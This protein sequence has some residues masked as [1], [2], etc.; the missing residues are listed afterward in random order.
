MVRQARRAGRLIVGVA[1]TRDAVRR[2]TAAAVLIAE[3][4]NSKDRLLERWRD[5]EVPI[6]RGWTKDELGELAG[7]PAVAVM[8]VTDRHMAAGIVAIETAA[9][10]AA[11]TTDEER[12]E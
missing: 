12:E 11:G 8:A 6:S 2:G 1:L 3:D 5:S 7:K 10:G 4:L 9:R